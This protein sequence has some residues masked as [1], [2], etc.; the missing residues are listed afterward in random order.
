MGKR[1]PNP[2]IAAGPENRRVN[3]D[4]VALR[5]EQR[6]TAIAGLIAASVWIIPSKT[7]SPSS[8]N[9]RPRELITPVVRVPSSPNGFPIANT[10]WPTWR[11]SE[12]PK[13]QKWK[14]LFRQD[15]H[16]RQI[17]TRITSKDLPLILRFVRQRHDHFRKR[18]H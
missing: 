3:T 10:F 9:V 1:K 14:L 17:I 7:R 6:S 15:L 16:Q 2:D 4:D 13:P 8:R 18:V 12:S 11:L 5:I